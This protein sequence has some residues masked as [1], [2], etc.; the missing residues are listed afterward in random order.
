MVLSRAGAAGRYDKEG[1]QSPEPTPMS[2]SPTPGLGGAGGG[3]SGDTD[4]H[5]SVLL[6]SL[7]PGGEES[8]AAIFCP[9]S[10]LG[11]K[12]AWPQ[13]PKEQLALRERLVPGGALSHPVTAARA[14][15]QPLRMASSPSPLLAT[16]P[17]LQTLLS[18]K[19]T[20]TT[21]GKSRGPGRRLQ[22]FFRLLGTWGKRGQHFLP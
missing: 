6:P 11:E 4:T 5:R 2:P 1:T 16:T 3:C 13:E 9:A 21:Q 17:P 18:H 7:R 15:C 12:R 20:E 19:T 22:P 14:Q 8:L 10:D